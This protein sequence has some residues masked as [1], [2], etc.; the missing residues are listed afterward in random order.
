LIS[1]SDSSKEELFES[2]AAFASGSE[3]VASSAN[4]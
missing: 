4:I 2:I 1:I 3:K